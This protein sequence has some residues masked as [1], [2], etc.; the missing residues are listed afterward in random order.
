VSRWQCCSASTQLSGNNNTRLLNA[1][2][3]GLASQE[4]RLS[5]AA[6]ASE[7]SSS[8]RS[9][10]ERSVDKA[11][12]CC[13]FLRVC[14]NCNPS[15]IGNSCRRSE[16]RV[17]IDFNCTAS[18]AAN[19]CGHDALALTS[20]SVVLPA[21]GARSCC[22]GSRLKISPLSGCRASLSA[23]NRTPTSSA[24]YR[25]AAVSHRRNQRS[26]SLTRREGGGKRE[27]RL[28]RLE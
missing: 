19:R 18:C 8:N 6:S 10:Y 12:R 2:T 3:C 14:N 27:V 11:K 15:S 5:S 7:T 16:L 17:G 25:V 28:S 9:G 24:A 21:K 4:L 23:A 20:N 26:Y 13:S 1:V 22:E